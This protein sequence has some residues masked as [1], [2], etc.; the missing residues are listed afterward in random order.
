MGIIRRV[1]SHHFGVKSAPPRCHWTPTA[2]N[3]ILARQIQVSQL[4]DYRRALLNLDDPWCL[5]LRMWHITA[6]LGVLDRKVRNSCREAKT[7]HASSTCSQIEAALRAYDYRAVWEHCRLP[8]GHSRRSVK[9]RAVPPAKALNPVALAPHRKKVFGATP[10][11][12]P[13][14][15]SASATLAWRSFAGLE[16]RRSR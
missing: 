15:S 6:R 3:A 7:R 10:S 16:S 13:P 4:V 11:P 12:A 5:F 1:A 14:P 9:P 2:W 8:A